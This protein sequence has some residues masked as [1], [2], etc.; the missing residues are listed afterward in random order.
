MVKQICI[1]GVTGYLASWVAKKALDSGEY[2]VRGTVRSKKSKDV[3]LLLK[4][5]E[6]EDSKEEIE[7]V[8]ADLL[9]PDGWAEAFQDCD[10]VI[11]TASPIYL[12]TPDDPENQLI[13][14]AVEGTTHVLEACQKS[15]VTRCVVTSTSGTIC[16]WTKGDRTLTEK[17]FAKVQKTTFPYFESK[18]RAEEEMWRIAE[19]KDNKVEIVSMHPTFLAGPVLFKKGGSSVTFIERMLTGE[20]SAAPQVYFNVVDVRDTAE[21]HLKGLTVEIDKDDVKKN[22]FIINEGT[23][24]IVSIGEMLHREFSEYGYAPPTSEIP[25]AIFWMVACFNN[26]ANSIYA[27]WNVKEELDNTKA[28]EVLGIKFNTTKNAILDMGYSMIE[29]GLVENKMK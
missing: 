17:D 8:E 23:Y 16:E 4:A 3:D 11:H 7:L 9:S 18:I 12:D 14:P 5:L 25:C 29:H 13:K 1:T 10:Y 22:R 26:D 24:K 19:E 20:L 27:Q 28:K 6:T 15:G 21:A 2:K